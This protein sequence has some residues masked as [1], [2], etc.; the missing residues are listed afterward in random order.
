VKMEKLIACIGLLN[1]YKDDQGHFIFSYNGNMGATV[2]H[3]IKPL[4]VK[5][6]GQ[7]ATEVCLEIGEQEGSPDYSWSCMIHED[8]LINPPD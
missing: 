4:M 7:K 5:L 2:E 3:S 8:D 1:Q 6:I